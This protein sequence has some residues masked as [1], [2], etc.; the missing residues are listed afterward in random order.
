MDIDFLTPT[1]PSDKPRM[2]QFRIILRSENDIHKAASGGIFF[3][4]EETPDNFR[5]LALSWIPNAP[6]VAIFQSI[7][8]PTSSFPV[9]FPSQ[10]KRD[11]GPGISIQGEF[12]QAH[13]R[14][15]HDV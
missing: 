3:T 5:A 9:T 14:L 1:D 12:P 8:Y 7:A 4:L 15:T 6:C 11:H 10:P 13:R 2:S